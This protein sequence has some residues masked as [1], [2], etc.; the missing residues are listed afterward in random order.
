VETKYWR[1]RRRQIA[2]VVDEMQEQGIIVTP[3]SL[4]DFVRAKGSRLPLETA[5]LLLHNTPVYVSTEEIAT[6]S[7]PNSE[8]E[9]IKNLDAAAD[10][11]A[12]FDVMKMVLSGSERRC[13]KMVYG[14]GCPQRP[15][16][17][18][19]KDLGVSVQWISKLKTSAM[20]KLKR[21]YRGQCR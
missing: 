14:I 3:E 12:L 4:R 13:I 2:K 11:E 6:L 16:V 18:I 19:A 17:E 10:R 9:M 20:R 15:Y 21:Y 7:A 5:K 8:A 1:Q